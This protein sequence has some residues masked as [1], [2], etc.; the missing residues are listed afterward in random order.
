MKHITAE[1][2]R[3]YKFGL[4][5]GTEAAEVAAHLEVCAAC[6]RKFQT[7]EKQFQALEVLLDQPKVSEETLAA[8]FAANRKVNDPRKI[9]RFHQFSLRQWRPALVAAALLMTCFA[10]LKYAPPEPATDEMAQRHAV[11]TTPVV[12]AL[13]NVASHKDGVATSAKEKSL[14]ELRTQKPFVP[15]SN[16][17]LNVLP[18]RDD[19]QLTIYNEEDLT[20]VREKRRLTLKRGW[21]WLQFMWSNTLIDPTSLELEP[22]T[23][24]DKI[25]IT[26][27]VYP[28]RLNELAR[29]TV[30]SEISGEVEFELTYFTSG[31]RWTA[32]YEALLTP[33]EQTMELTSYVR[34]NNN[35]GEDYEDAQ[36]RL[37][38]GQINLIDPIKPLALQQYAYN[39]PDATERMRSTGREEEDRL[40]RT[41]EQLSDTKLGYNYNF[42]CA[43]T[44]PRLG[45]RNKKQIIKQGLSEYQLYTIEGRETIPNGW[46]KRLPSLEAHE[47]G[48][49]N[50]YKYDEERWGKK[51]VRFLSFSNTDAHGLG[52]TPLPNG[53]VRVFRH[54]GKDNRLVY[55]GGSNM[56]YI[57]IGGKVELELG[58]ARKVRVEPKL[59][60][61]RTE[62]YS[63]D[64]RGNI[65]GWDEIMDWKIELFNAR[66]L[67]VKLEITRKT[68]SKNWEII[69]DRSAAFEK[70]DATH[71]RFTIEL[72]PH[73]KKVFSYKL[74]THHGTRTE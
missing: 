21:N 67:P 26:Q 34:V 50:L 36:T 55:V 70:Y 49:T 52:K 23:F 51:P 22:K 60:R 15:A 69:Y 24:M 8:V 45:K 6:R 65:S 7:L 68:G 2:L 59:M 53:C 72:P 71:A 17:E 54:S 56:N 37:V 73:T 11:G 40:Y 19:V 3:E 13:R 29:W 12:T 14:A 33:D 35:S 31:L 9:I 38:V 58:T 57:P 42:G 10:I 1:K 43:I 41:V 32:F 28:P 74:T 39:R 66:H 25:E 62:N 5:N 20:L 46:G 16:I 64:H 30:F 44:A 18:Q 61:M 27:Q 4:L 48:V 47:I 63:F